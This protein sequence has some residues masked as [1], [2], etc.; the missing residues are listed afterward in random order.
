M[1]HLLQLLSLELFNELN[2][3]LWIS[4]VHLNLSFSYDFRANKNS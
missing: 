3:T 2:M 4:L 1:F